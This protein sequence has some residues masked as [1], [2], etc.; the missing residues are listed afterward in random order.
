MTAVLSAHMWSQKF[1][2]RNR[3]QRSGQALTRSPHMHVMPDLVRH[4]DFVFCISSICF[5]ANREQKIY[6]PPL[7]NILE[8]RL[9]KTTEFS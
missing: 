4:P 7:S 1:V 2:T 3:K 8:K 6:I 5:G 9:E